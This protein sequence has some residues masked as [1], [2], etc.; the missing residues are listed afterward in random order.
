LKDAELADF[1]ASS[2]RIDYFKAG[3]RPFHLGQVYQ[4]YAADKSALVMELDSGVIVYRE[5]AFFFMIPAFLLLLFS[6]RWGVRGLQIVLIAG[7]SFFVLPEAVAAAE[8]SFGEQFDAAVRMLEAGEASDAA[9]SFS[10]LYAAASRDGTN[11][12]VLAAVQFNL[13]LSLTLRA[14]VEAVESPSQALAHARAARDAFLSAKRLSPQMERAGVRVVS[15][16]RVIEILVAAGELDDGTQDRLSEMIER[17]EALWGAQRELR[18]QSKTGDPRQAGTSSS[19]G[20][21]PPGDAAE[22]A[23]AYVQFQAQ[24]QEAGLEIQTQMEELNRQITAN[25]EGGMQDTANLLVECLPILQRAIDAQGAALAL[26]R[27]WESWPAARSEGRAVEDSLG[28]ILDLLKASESSGPTDEMGDESAE[29]FQAGEELSDAGAGQ[30]SSQSSSADFA[31]DVEMQALPV[32]NYSVEDILLEEQGSR[33]F[34][35]QNRARA[36]A[37]Q[38]ERDY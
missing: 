31:S 6:E 27:K 21:Q 16:G 28:E 35:E 14:E 18:E 11:A 34:R 5:A 15:M 8:G 36:N 4:A 12:E 19:Q 26:Y 23:E 10:A 2:A 22:R 37:G 13:G 3:T 20:A 33:Q 29:D 25:I 7:L 17:I 1:A 24:M 38:V 9:Q 30:S 32:P